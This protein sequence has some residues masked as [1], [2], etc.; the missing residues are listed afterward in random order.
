M[1]DF[2]SSHDLRGNVLIRGFET[3]FAP[4][5]GARHVAARDEQKEL[6]ELAGYLSA[7]GHPRRLELLGKLRFPR[8]LGEIELRPWRAEAEGNPD[9]AMSRNAVE[10]H[11]QILRAIG[12]VLRR[13]GERDGRSVDEW[14]LAH[15]RLFQVVEELRELSRLRPPDPADV[16][17]TV[18]GEARRFRGVVAEGPHLTILTG[19]YEGRTRLLEGPG[20][21]TLG[22]MASC[23]IALDYDPYVSSAHCEVARVPDGFGVRDLPTN[24][25]GTNLN[26]QTMPRGQQV[27]LATGD[28]LGVGRTLVLFHAGTR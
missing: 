12:V 23:E 6:E 9:R 17:Q 26:W 21:W 5:R 7:L 3:A 14:L 4:G 22:R 11:L 10:R 13:P 1:A 19:P 16:P 8:T 15:A 25:N 2:A 20:P 28:V 24:R 27:P 18:V